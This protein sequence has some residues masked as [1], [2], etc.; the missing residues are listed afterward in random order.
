MEAL[1]PLCEIAYKYHT[2]KGP[3]ENP[4]AH[5]YTS[6][7]HDLLKNRRDSI[8]R[9]VEIGLG[10]PGLMHSYYEAAGSLLMWRDY[11]PNA[12]IFGLDIRPD[13]L[14]NEARIHSFL[15]DQSNEVSLR[16]AATR[17]GADFDLIVDDGSHVPKDQVLTAKIFVPLLANGGLYIIEDVHDAELPFVREHLGFPHEIIECENEKLQGDRLIV[18][19]A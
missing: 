17:I 9:V 18:I 5:A 1:T 4:L 13:A 3:S 7:Y 15:C 16:S 8:K 11:F 14:R 6:H 2:D 10:W 12:E 19:R